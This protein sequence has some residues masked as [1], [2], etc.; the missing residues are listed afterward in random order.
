MGPDAHVLVSMG[1]EGALLVTASRVVEAHPPRIE[2]VN[3]VGCGD[4][5]LAGYVDASGRFSDPEDILR[6]AV[7]F[8]SAAALQPVAGIAAAQDIEQIRSRVKV[9]SIPARRP[10]QQRTP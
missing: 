7:A 6:Q 5:L 10:D 2:V 9:N 1:S 8:G 4:A 3:T